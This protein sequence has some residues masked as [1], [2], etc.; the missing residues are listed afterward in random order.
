[1]VILKL[2]TATSSGPAA[3]MPPAQLRSHISAVGQQKRQASALQRLE[4]GLTRNSAKRYCHE[5]GAD[6]S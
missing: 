3:M 1:M 4:P 2:A 6:R 5:A